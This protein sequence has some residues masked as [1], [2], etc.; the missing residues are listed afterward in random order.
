MQLEKY[1]FWKIAFW[2]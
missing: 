2:W 1:R